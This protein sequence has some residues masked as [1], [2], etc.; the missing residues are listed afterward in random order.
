L[1]LFLQLSQGSSGEVDAVIPNM[2]EGELMAAWINVQVTVWCHYYW[3]ATNLGGE[4]FYRK[5]SDRAFSQVL[6]HE[7][8]KCVWDAEEMSMTSPNAQSELSAVMEFENQDWVKNIAQ[9]NQ[10][11]LKKKHVDPNAAFPFQDD[12]SVRTIHGK[13][14]AAQSKDQA[15][16][17]GTKNATNFIEISNTDNDIHVLTSKMQDKLLALLVQERHKSKSKAGNRIAS[18]SMPLVSGLTANA[19]PTRA[20]GTAPIAIE[21]SLIPSSA[22]TEGRVDGRPGGKLLP[23]ITPLNPWEG[24][25]DVRLVDC[26]LG[27]GLQDTEETSNV[28]HVIVVQ[29]W[30]IGNIS[31]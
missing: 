28:Q 25:Q 1:P 22:G 30:P 9:A 16:G 19:T 13:N 6:L 23:L 27:G 29:C 14:M 5:L 21:G 15:D 4:R 20:T 8:S 2:P 12:F 3:K 11:N 18:S 10:H 31:Y 17:M 7:I 24:S 26:F